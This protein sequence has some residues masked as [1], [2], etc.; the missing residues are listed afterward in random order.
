MDWNIAW[1]IV[2]AGPALEIDGRTY[3]PVRVDSGGRLLVALA[4]GSLAALT[5][6]ASGRE[7]V[8]AAGTEEQM[9]TVT[10]VAVSVK[11]L[12]TNTGVVY[13]GAAGVSSAN[14]REMEPGEV[15]DL[16]VDNVNRLWLD[17]A[18]NG[19]GVTYLALA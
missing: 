6:V 4:L 13:L 9:P 3:V 16:A 15:L 19:E 2:D 7:T 1:G 10:C 12:S 11:A 5:T 18:V 17:V 14:G 8:A